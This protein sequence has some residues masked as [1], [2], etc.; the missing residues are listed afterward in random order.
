M[1]SSM[2]IERM[3][4]VARIKGD[5]NVEKGNYS[6]FQS[7]PAIDRHGRPECPAKPLQDPHKP[8]VK[9]RFF[10]QKGLRGIQF[11][12]FVEAVAAM[13]SRLDVSYAQ[14]AGLQHQRLSWCWCLSRC[15]DLAGRVQL[16]HQKPAPARDLPKPKLIR[17]S[18][19]DARRPCRPALSS[20]KVYGS[21]RWI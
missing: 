2:Y 11:P 1:N 19:N 16:K 8:H 9:I 3:P 13:R 20:K 7:G 5:G 10:A 4:N 14:S 6:D 12:S 18:G 17:R 15:L 21:A